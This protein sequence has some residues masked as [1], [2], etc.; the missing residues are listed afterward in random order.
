MHI[1]EGRQ[2]SRSLRR[3]ERRT[4][5]GK[6]VVHYIQRTP[7][8]AKCANCGKALHGVARAH[9]GKLGKLSKSERGPSRPHSGQ[10]CS[11]CSRAAIITKYRN[12]FSL[13]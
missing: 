1:N 7:A 2:K 6:I 5:K 13:K 3:I 11:P 4:P 10:L 12:L 8:K 9:A